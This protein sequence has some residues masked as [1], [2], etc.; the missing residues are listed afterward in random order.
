MAT[1]RA[2][3]GRANGAKARV[4]DGQDKVAWSRP[5]G[6]PALAQPQ[7]VQWVRPM[8]RVRRRQEVA[9]PVNPA[10]AHR[11]L[12]LLRDARIEHVPQHAAMTGNPVAPRRM[13]P[14]SV[15]PNPRVVTGN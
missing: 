13:S 9:G 8:V 7:G 10:R 6:N 3:A 4:R 2:K 5:M 14:G 15:S 12:N 1:L 11:G